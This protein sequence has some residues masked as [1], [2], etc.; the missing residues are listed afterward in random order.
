[1][2]L[3]CSYFNIKMGTWDD[4]G[5]KLVSFDPKTLSITCR[6]YHLTQFSA[7]IYKELPNTVSNNITAKNNFTETTNQT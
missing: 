6:A 5:M 1:L 3:G 4:K 2:R 7:F